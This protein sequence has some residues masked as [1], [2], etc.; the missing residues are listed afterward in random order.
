MPFK[1]YDQMIGERLKYLRN[2]SEFSQQDLA[3][4]LNVSVDKIKSYENGADRIPADK[5]FELSTIL[6]SPI[7]KFFDQAE[8]SKS[9]KLVSNQETKYC[10]VDRYEKTLKLIKLFLDIKDRETQ[11]L[12]ISL[13][14]KLT[15]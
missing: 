8:N 10:D 13:V 12:V 4:L 9:T 2:L 1:N 3:A 5:L 7:S 6:N 11:D 14:Q 15:K